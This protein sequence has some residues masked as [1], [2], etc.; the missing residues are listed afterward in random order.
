LTEDALISTEIKSGSITASVT[1]DE[2]FRVITDRTGS[3]IGSQFTGSVDVSGS[4]IGDD[5]TARG[6]L[7]G[8]GRFITNVQ[9]A[10]APLIASGSATA[11]V[12][13]GDTFIVTTGATGSV[14]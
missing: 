7:F 9:A 2:G 3:Q 1:P 6:F 13:S 11:S 5:L 14:I 8:D 10:A 4:L 12:A